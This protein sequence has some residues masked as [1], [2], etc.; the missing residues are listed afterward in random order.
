MA[1]VRD[2]ARV[3]AYIA[4]RDEGKPI[5]IT[6]LN[7]CCTS[8]RVMHWLNLDGRCLIIKSTHGSMVPS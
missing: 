6:R 3:F 7:N 1:N 4:D 2:V 8:R 5:E